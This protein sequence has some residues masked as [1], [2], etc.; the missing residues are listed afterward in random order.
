MIKLWSSKQ[1]ATRS[2]VELDACD[3]ISWELLI[4]SRLVLSIQESS[5]SLVDEL[6]LVFETSLVICEKV[7]SPFMCPI[8]F[9]D[10]I[11]RRLLFS[12]L[13]TKLSDESPFTI[14]IWNS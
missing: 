11:T 1:L 3:V 9:L 14:A 8:V 6:D 10:S 4:C 12:T 7:K 13:S 2:D 5:F